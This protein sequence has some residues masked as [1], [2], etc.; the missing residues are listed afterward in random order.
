[1]S[2]RRPFRPLALLAASL[3]ACGSAQAA[4]WGYVDGRGVAHVAT[5]QV[6]SRYSLVLGDAAA[7]RVFGKTDSAGG[8]L[9]WLEIAPEVKAVQHL[10]REASQKHGVDV[11]LLKALI[12]VE[13]GFNAK[14]VSPRG[15]IGLMQLMPDTADRYATQRE[16][17]Q[18][19]EKRLFDARTNIFTGA[20]MLADLTR[21]FGSID[22]ALAAWNAGEGRVRRAGGMPQIDETL[23]HVQ[24]VLELY[25]ALLQRSLPK[26]AQEMRLVPAT[27]A[28]E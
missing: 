22:L 9:T 13:S 27:G 15:A 10:L 4:L 16:R 26:Q 17:Q 3:L 6:D 11:E 14:A 7:P 8:L 12:A 23:G 20:R 25:W 1:M 28:P 21:R 19:A 24:M 5:E 2:S 18:P